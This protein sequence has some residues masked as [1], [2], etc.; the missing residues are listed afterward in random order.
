MTGNGHKA[1]GVGAAFIA[2]ALAVWLNVPELPAAIAAL[3]SCTAPDR[4]ELPRYRNGTRVGTVIPHRTIT[5]WPPLWLALVYVA[6]SGRLPI[7]IDSLVLGL[8][9]GAL[10][11]I[12]GD[13][14]NPMGIPWLKPHKRIRLGKKGLWRSGQ[15]EIP[16]IVGYAVTGYFLWRLATGWGPGQRFWV[17]PWSWLDLAW[18]TNF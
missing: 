17:V 12:L 1:T 13:A 10:T 16:I 11:H 6:G 4:I 15:Y 2:A 14:P 18:L 3:I 5:H 7:G 9:V 8:A